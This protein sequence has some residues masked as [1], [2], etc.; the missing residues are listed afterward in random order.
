MN[1][2]ATITVTSA[3][4]T[5]YNA[6]SATFTVTVNKNLVGESVTVGGNAFY[7]IGDDGTN[8]TLLYKSA[9]GLATW[10]DAK[11]QASEFGRNLGGTGRL[12]T[13]A[14]ARGVAASYRNIGTSYWLA[15]PYDSSLS[16]FVPEDGSV[17]GTY[18]NVGCKVRPVVVISKSKL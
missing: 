6:K 14:E 15:D 5:N 8:V 13:V 2:T 12:M 7:V 10:K 4:T 9:Y 18:I 11:S 17:S 3:A 16:W 1:G